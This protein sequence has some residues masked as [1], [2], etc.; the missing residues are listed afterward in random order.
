MHREFTIKQLREP[1]IAKSFP[2]AQVLG[3]SDLASWRKFVRRHEKG[4]AGAE[5][6]VI[7]AENA[8]GYVAGL[9][10]YQVKREGVDGASLFCDPFLVADL[11]RFETPVRALLEAADRIAVEHGCKWVRI[12]L[13]ATGE[14]LGPE[15]ASCHAALFRAGYAL[16]SMSFRR[17][18]SLPVGDLRPPGSKY[19]CRPR[20]FAR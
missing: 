18:R 11:P 6:G 19:P 13:P 4:K 20:T 3:L 2:F 10:F 14:T 1:L 5:S 15:G 7:V 16:E 12:V 9:L 8:Q 17:R